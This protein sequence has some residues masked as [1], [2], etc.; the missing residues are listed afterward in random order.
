MKTAPQFESSPEAICR[1]NTHVRSTHRTCAARAW[2]SC[3]ALRQRR[4]RR[5]HD[6]Q[7]A[8]R[9]ARRG[10]VRPRRHDP[11]SRHDH[12]LRVGQPLRVPRPPHGLPAV[13]AVRRR[14]SKRTFEEVAAS[15]GYQ[16]S[17]VASF[18]LYGAAA[19]YA[20]HNPRTRG[21]RPSAPAC[22]SGPGCSR[23]WRASTRWCTRRC[24]ARPPSA[25]HH[26]PATTIG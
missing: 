9:H 22:T 2:A 16:R 18:G 11:G 20:S 19:P 21:T 13:V 17:N 5:R 12:R 10:R 8:R 23:R 3:G 6:E 4:R 25:A 15:L 14:P 26:R 7:G 1:T 24:R